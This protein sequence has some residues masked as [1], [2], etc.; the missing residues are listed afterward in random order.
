MYF[1][2]FKEDYVQI[3][4][5]R[6]RIP[7]FCPDAHQCPKVLNCSR[8]HLSRRLSNLSEPSSM[9]DK[10]SNFL[11]RHRYGRQLHPSKRQVYTVRMLSLVR[12]DVEKNCNHPNVRATPS[13]CQ[14]LLWKLRAAKVQLSRRGPD[15]VLREARYGKPVAQLSIQRLSAT[16]QTPPREI[17]FRLV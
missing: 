6:S 12:Q 4:S 5:Q 13:G 15:M 11:L 8:L 7:S 10:K 3:P 14:S 1:K 2:K 17:R 9:F 16:V